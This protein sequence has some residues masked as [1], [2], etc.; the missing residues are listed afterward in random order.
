MLFKLDAYQFAEYFGKLFKYDETAGIVF[1]DIE[2]DKGLHF[3][4]AN[5]D[6]YAEVDFIYETFRHNMPLSSF[7]TQND[8]FEADLLND[9]TSKTGLLITDA[10]DATLRAIELNGYRFTKN[11][12]LELIKR[13]RATNPFGEQ[14]PCEIIGHVGY[15]YP[16][17]VL[18]VIKKAA[19]K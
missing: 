15:Y 11:V 9:I 19:K 13:L 14:Y 10:K 17:C 6:L 18:L 1:R 5:L 7:L 4:V 2:K 3:D 12:L 8:D 16:A